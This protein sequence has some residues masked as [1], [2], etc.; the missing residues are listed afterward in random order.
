MQLSAVY[1]RSFFTAQL[2]KKETDI[3]VIYLFSQSAGPRIEPGPWPVT[4]YTLQEKILYV[5]TL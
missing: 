2:V 5:I 3:Y 1:P 4:A